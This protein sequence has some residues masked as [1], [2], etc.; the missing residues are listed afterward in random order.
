MK[1]RDHRL[2]G[3]SETLTTFRSFKTS[4][5][6]LTSTIEDLEKHRKLSKSNRRERIQ[7]NIVKSS[8]NFSN[9]GT[10]ITISSQSAKVSG[11][12]LKSL[13]RCKHE[14]ETRD[15]KRVYEGM[16]NP[17][18]WKETRRGCERR[19]KTYRK[20]PD[21]IKYSSNESLGVSSSYSQRGRVKNMYKQSRSVKSRMKNQQ[22]NTDHSDYDRLHK[23]R[24]FGIL[25][26]ICNDYTD[27]LDLDFKLHLL[28][29]VELCRSIK[30]ALMKTLQPDDFYKVDTM[31]KARWRESLIDAII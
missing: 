24:V 16:R 6:S 15:H 28:R 17:D 27:D 10:S 12:N 9:Y 26:D 13:E 30:R 23:K 8:C 18:R 19:A 29:Y 25:T 14:E 2:T 5:N 22:K 1:F 20:V 3:G 4:Y 11:N 21:E 7:R 31:S